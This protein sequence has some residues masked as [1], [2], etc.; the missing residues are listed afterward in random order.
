MYCILK[1][2][3]ASSSRNGA[4]GANAFLLLWD[5]AND[6]DLISLQAS[7]ADNTTANAA[8]SPISSTSSTQGTSAPDASLAGAASKHFHDSTP[9][10]QQ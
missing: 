3:Q 7:S 10:D 6:Q 5:P 8:P 9:C 4:A 2:I 1:Q